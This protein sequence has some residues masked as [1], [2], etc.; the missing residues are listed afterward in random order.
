MAYM[1]LCRWSTSDVIVDDNIAAIKEV[2]E[3][4][5]IIAGVPPSHGFCHWGLCFWAPKSLIYDYFNQ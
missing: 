5:D 4:F 1:L 3:D 2:W